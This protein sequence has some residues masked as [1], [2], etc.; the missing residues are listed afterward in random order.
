MLIIFRNSWH[1]PA[2]FWPAD[3]WPTPWPDQIRV[4]RLQ[5][6][7]EASLQR[8]PAV[9]AG[10][11]SQCVLTPPVHFIVPRFFLSLR[12]TCAETVR[13]RMFAWIRAQRPGPY[14]PGLEAATVNVFIAD[15]VDLGG[16]EFCRAVVALNAKL[17][18]PDSVENVAVRA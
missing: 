13:S 5:S 4:D 15:F 14:Q 16:A 11:V 1:M 3:A 2:E 8:R 12:R 10:Y 17:L 9:G 18:T 6:Y 7:L